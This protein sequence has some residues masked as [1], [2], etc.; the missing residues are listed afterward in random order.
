MNGILKSI[1]CHVCNLKWAF[2]ARSPVPSYQFFLVAPWYNFHPYLTDSQSIPSLPIHVLWSRLVYIRS[3]RYLAVMSCALQIQHGQNWTHQFLILGV[4]LLCLIQVNFTPT[5][6]SIQ[7]PSLD[8]VLTSLNPQP[9]ATK[10]ATL[11]CMLLILS[12]LQMTAF[13]QIHILSQP[14]YFFF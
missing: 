2:M 5:Y 7:V 12:V 9:T 3:Q 14:V 1:P 6:I 4:S 8:T 11:N 10:S 13:V